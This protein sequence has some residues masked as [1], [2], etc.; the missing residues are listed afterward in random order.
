MLI[1]AALSFAIEKNP[2]IAACMG[3]IASA[4]QVGR[5]GNIPLSL[6]EFTKALDL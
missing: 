6:E 4:I 3:S 1:T 2:F 5:M